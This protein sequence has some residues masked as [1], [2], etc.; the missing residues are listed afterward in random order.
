MK[1]LLV[2]LAKMIGHNGG[3][4]KVACL[5]SNELAK[6]GGQVSLV[7]SD[8]KDGAFFFPLDKNIP[9]YDLRRY[10]GK[11]LRFPLRLKIKREWLRMFDK[12]KA[13]NVN[14][15]FE[16]A[17]CLPH[18]REIIEG[19]N[20][21]IIISF[22]PLASRLLLCELKTEIPVITMSHGDPEDYFHTYPKGELPALEKSAVCQVLM[23]S[24]ERTLRNHFPHVRTAVIG[25]AI[26]QY[27]KPADL[28]A[29]KKTHKIIF[30]GRL[31]KS[32]KRPHLLIEAFA[33]LAKDFPDW[34]VE[35][36]GAAD[37]KAYYKELQL[38]IR[39]N[40][41]EKQV[42]LCGATNDVESV[43]REG[44]IF[45]FPS[46][47]EGF[48]MSLAEGMSM[49]L[50]AIGYKNCAGVNELIRDDVD[51]F[52]CEDGVEDFRNHLRALMKDRELRIRMGQAARKAMAAYAPEKIWDAWE[53]V[54]TETI[55]NRSQG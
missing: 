25:N 4:Q 8:G 3:M 46:A 26:P 20:P 42:F 12:R 53:H 30:T 45:A 19:V 48:G 43:L 6:R 18:L 55:K 1:V 27:E 23:P 22:Q 36:W 9:T 47:Y 5:M 37:G 50:P 17:F 38:L 34:N 31:A 54:I 39:K 32:H 11:T 24:Y 44:D 33:D 13:R 10:Q 15:E 28:A 2:N 21:D 52:L 35:L 7:Y 29:D 51:G 14:D 41:L 49:G 16:I 40:H